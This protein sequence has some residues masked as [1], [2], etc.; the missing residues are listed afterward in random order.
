MK[1]IVE[2]FLGI[3]TAVGGFVEVGE[4]VFS[5]NA[6][7]KFR[8]SLLWV[9]ALGTVGII[10]YC[11]MAGRIAAVRA[12]PVFNLV[13]E[14]AGLDAGLVTLG[15]ATMVSL[16]TCS[17]EIGGIALVWQL[18]S[19][20]PYRWLILIAFLFLLLCVW[21][22]SFQW[23]ERAFGLLGLLMLVFL[24]A[25]VLMRPDW[26]QVAWGLVPQAPQLSSPK[27]YFVFAYFG[28]ALLS[29]VMLPYETY[30]YAS[31]AIED[32]WTPS[33]IKLNRIICVVGMVLGSSLAAALV[34][35]GAQ[36][37]GPREIEP[38]LPGAAALGPAAV[39][40]K[41][42]L[43]VAIG[44]M[45]FAFAG[46]AIENALSGAYNLA[47]FLGWPWGK[48]RPARKA[49]RFTLSWMA[50]LALSTLVIMTGVDP[51][52]VVEYSI[53]FAVVLLPFTYFPVM[54]IANDKDFMGEFVNG[55]FANAV[56]WFYLAV[57]TLAALLA[58]P[59]LIITGGGQ[60]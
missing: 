55:R 19:G 45:F 58:L 20:W 51:V 6:G 35:I 40:G 11:E 27:E 47:Q 29:S 2:L 1:K 5:V 33:D 52:S 48:Y 44:G 46:A 18:L 13:R 50:I 21:V 10:V 59:L 22:L 14:R 43:V 25:A 3:L 37:F 39:Y 36:L 4:L 49:A 7:A 38:Q 60:G 53:I 17:A 54:V 31:G 28:V 42:G 16:L 26:G 24:A 9:L 57:V 41:A 23:I 8:F 12:Q 34:I 15:A 30:F 56:G 32:G